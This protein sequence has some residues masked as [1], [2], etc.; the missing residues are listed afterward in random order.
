MRNKLPKVLITSQPPSSSFL[1]STIKVTIAMHRKTPRMARE[2]TQTDNEFRNQK[3]VKIRQSAKLTAAPGHVDNCELR[4]KPGA[5]ITKPFNNS[6]VS[7]VC[8]LARETTHRS[9]IFVFRGKNI[10][11]SLLR[12]SK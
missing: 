1:S 8:S 9:M 5:I 6:Y 4:F 2:S 3:P 10:P 7:F 11:Y 12:V